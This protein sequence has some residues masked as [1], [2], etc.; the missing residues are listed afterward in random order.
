MGFLS[1]LAGVVGGGIGFLVGGGPAGAAAGFA[2]GSSIGA[3]GEGMAAEAD[4][5]DA[6]KAQRRLAQLENRRNRLELIREYQSALAT[7]AV[8]FEGS[9][10]AIESSGF[11]GVRSSLGAQVKGNLIY[12]QKGGQLS[13][14]YYNRMRDSYN[15]QSSA[16]LLQGLSSA[17]GSLYNVM[18]SGAGTTTGSTT[19]TT[20]TTTPPVVPRLRTGA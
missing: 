5:K 10:A 15:H 20:P 17:A 7:S 12:N 14:E 6:A 16:N 18:Q 19:T 1:G 8:S 3:A 13:T 11:Q 2:I 4:A 9:G